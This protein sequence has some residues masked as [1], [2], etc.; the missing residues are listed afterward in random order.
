MAKYE[1]PDKRIVKPKRY[2]FLR[3]KRRQED[4]R[5]EARVRTREAWT[6]TQPKTEQ[7]RLG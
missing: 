7:R 4:M 5:A 2:A 3:L 1:T 6:E